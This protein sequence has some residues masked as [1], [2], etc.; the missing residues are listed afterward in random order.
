MLYVA[1]IIVS[2]LALSGWV[3]AFFYMIK[4]GELQ[5]EKIGRDCWLNA[6]GARFHAAK[7]IAT[8]RREEQDPFREDRVRKG[9]DELN[10]Y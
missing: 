9:V 2:V 7:A 6:C 3:L 10:S 8:E 4:T 1:L 5:E